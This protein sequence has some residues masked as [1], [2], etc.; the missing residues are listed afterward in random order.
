VRMVRFARFHASLRGDKPVNLVCLCGR[1]R[2]GDA[3]N[4]GRGVPDDGA[5]R[6]GG[7]GRVRSEALGRR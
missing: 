1:A 5:G 3:A 6:C 2:D 4:G 7:F